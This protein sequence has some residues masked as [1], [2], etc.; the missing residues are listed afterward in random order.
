[1]SLLEDFVNAIEQG[2]P[3]LVESLL[4]N[5]SIDVNA[6]LPCWLNPPPL[7]FAVRCEMCRVEVVEILLSAGARI[8]DVDDNGQTACFVATWARNVDVLAVLLTHCPNL[9]LKEK[10][11]N[12]TPLRLSVDFPSDSISILLINAGAS[13]DDLADQLC[14][15]A[16]RSIAAIQALLNRGVVLNQVF[17]AKNGTPLHMIASI[18]PPNAV[19]AVVKCFI[20][21]CG[22]DLE[23]VDSDG[24]TCTQIAASEGN[25][26]ALRCFIDAGANVNFGL[27]RVFANKCLVLLLAAGANVGALDPASRTGFQTTTMVEN[28]HLIR[29]ILPIFLAAGADPSGVCE[30]FIAAISVHEI[31][32]ARREIAKTRLDFVRHR[33]MQVCIGLR[34]LRLDALQLCEILQQSCGPV[35]HVIAFHQWWKISTTVKHFR[36]TK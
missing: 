2:D 15:L 33:A 35:A 31:E 1:M 7:V 36:M 17:D 14:W 34:S 8:D 3:F 27:H 18:A 6:R 22:V 32:S 28:C 23:A 12:F 19:E 20:T 29:P 21:D 11:S 4:A 25:S 30:E 13:L 5:G 16:S 10:W 26:T 24:L 9:E